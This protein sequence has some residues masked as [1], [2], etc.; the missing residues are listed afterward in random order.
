MNFRHP[1]I[2]VSVAAIL[3]TALCVSAILASYSAEQLRSEKRAQV[4]E[5]R[6]AARGLVSTVNQSLMK[7]IVG[8]YE[9]ELA[10][11]ESTASLEAS[12]FTAIGSFSQDTS[13]RWVDDWFVSRSPQVERGWFAK[14]ERQIQI[15]EVK[16]GEL[17]WV[18]LISE[19]EQ[20]LFAVLTRVQVKTG[21]ILK[22]KIVI[23][24]SSQALLSPINLVSKGNP[25]QIFAV[26]RE[27]YTYSYPEA[28]YVGAKIDTHPVVKALIS[29]DVGPE[30]SEYVNLDGAAIFGASEWVP[31]SNL[32]VIV[33]APKVSTRHLL[34]QFFTHAM[35][36]V[37]AL[38]ALVSVG[39]ALLMA[40]DG[41]ERSVLLRNL[42]LLQKPKDDKTTAN[43]NSIGVVPGA[44]LH[45]ATHL[46]VKEIVKAIA[47]Y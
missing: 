35:I 37:M 22:T 1:L 21:D 16:P 18:R 10:A 6:E 19:N 33:T 39:L 27:G 34:A 29:T 4:L 2:I 47:D 38:I 23:A 28:Q 13:N 44:S 31:D 43:E 46:A 40:R 9:R 14:I 26:D 8:V 32:A 30:V 42:E 7:T 20:V 12:E 25:T 41:R 15:G 24:I 36:I 17:T 5:L 3:I 11:P 45:S